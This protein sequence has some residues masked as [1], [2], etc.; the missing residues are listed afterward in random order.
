MAH[1]E[2]LTLRDLL[3]LRLAGARL[4]VLSACETGVPGIELPDEVIALSTGL[5][6]AGLGGVVASLWS[7]SDLSTMLLMARFY[8]HW[9][10]DGLA[11]P[12]ALRQAQVW[13]RDATNE[14]KAAYLRADVPQATGQRLP[15]YVAQAL[16]EQ[17][18]V[19]RQLD[20]EGNEFH[21]PFY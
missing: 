5:I 13:V 2:M 6:Q 17:K 1:D 7:V 14:E 12:E 15:G 4:A 10:R 18:R 20:P 19:T 9:K 8:E 11:P 16:Y 21:H 3:S